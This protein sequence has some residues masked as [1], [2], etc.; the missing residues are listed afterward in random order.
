M[1]ESNRTDATFTLPNRPA[2]SCSDADRSDTSPGS[3]S[4]ELHLPPPLDTLAPG[5]RV[6]VHTQNSTYYL[7]ML[8]PAD[9]AVLVR[10]GRYF[11]EP[12]EA[13]LLGCSGDA[14]PPGSLLGIGA[15]LELAV[16]HRIIRTS[17]VVAFQRE[18]AGSA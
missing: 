15:R 3:P 6:T 1:V 13:Q 18:T 10:G 9:R 7:V 14:R 5:E 8:R 16:G 17:P 4:P 11:R 2:L 12:T